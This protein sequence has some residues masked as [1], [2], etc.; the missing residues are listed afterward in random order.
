MIA[1]MLNPIAASLPTRAALAQATAALRSA[2]ARRPP[3][4]A[5]ADDTLERPVRR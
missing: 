2:F 5:D 4:P 3:H 1:H